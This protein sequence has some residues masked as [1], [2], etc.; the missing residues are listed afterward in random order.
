[1]NSKRN[2]EKYLTENEAKIA[3]LKEYNEKYMQNFDLGDL[4]HNIDNILRDF[5][6]WLFEKSI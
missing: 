2:C 4:K 5:V 6:E 1:M 3:F